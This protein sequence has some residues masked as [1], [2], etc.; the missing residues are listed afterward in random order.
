MA[1]ANTSPA[2]ISTSAEGDQCVV[3]RRIGWR[4]YLTMLRVRGDR[5]RPSMIY[6]DGDL[7]LV[8]PAMVHERLS[9]RI[10][11]FVTLVALGLRV[12]C[13]H[14][15]HTTFRWRAKKG[16]VEGDHTYYF[17]NEARV[18]GKT[19][20]DLRV[21][22]P[23]DLAIEIVHTHK[24]DDALKVYRRLGVPEVWVCDEEELIIRV[25]RPSGRYARVASSVC[26]PDLTAADV[27]EW[28]KKPWETPDLTWMEDVQRW[29]RDVLGP[30]AQRRGG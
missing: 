5:S 6:L 25:L 14:T 12:D 9:Q 15:G 1:T 27:L 20:V 29:V 8:S 11:L 10:G 24:A 28:M 16:G 7:S 18:R 30:R 22:P 13:L 2:A 21:D 23:P 19:E 4:G 3:L 17:A 26:L